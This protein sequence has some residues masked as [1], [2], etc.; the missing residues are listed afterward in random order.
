MTATT[1]AAPIAAARRSR[2]S[3]RGALTF[4][5]ITLAL[6]AVSIGAWLAVDRIDRS[7]AAAATA[8]A[9]PVFRTWL[10]PIDMVGLEKQLVRAGYSIEVDGTLDPVTK[11]A[12]A[13][14]LRPSSLD[15]LSPSLAASLQG[16]VITT[17]R[18]PAAWNMR[19]GLTRRTTFVERPLTGPEGQLD[20][21]GNIRRG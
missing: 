5:G 18:D 16:T 20:A 6:A 17:R 2:S 7:S 15:P 10:P 12:L 9:Q 13:D 8:G 11:A 1:I 4:A 3:R 21:N 14:F 19:F